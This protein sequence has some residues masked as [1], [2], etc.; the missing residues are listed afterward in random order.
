M[1]DGLR[2]TLASLVQSVRTHGYA[3]AVSAPLLA[4]AGAVGLAVFGVTGS[5]NRA[6]WVLFLSALPALWVGGL[7]LRR[8]QAALRDE[9]VLLAALAASGP[10][11]LPDDAMCTVS[12]R[13]LLESLRLLSRREQ[14][15]RAEAERIGA[16]IE[17]A[18]RL[19][20]D[21][22]ASMGHDLRGPLNSMLGF[23]ELLLLDSDETA[24]RQRPS[25]TT[26]R[27]RTL[28]LLTLLDEMLDWARLSA[29]RMALAARRVSAAALLDQVT[30][31]LSQRLAGRPLR[32]HSELI[33]NPPDVLA[34]SRRIA[35][36][37]VAVLGDAI[38]GGRSNDVWLQLREYSRGGLLFVVNDPQLLIRE[39]DQKR[40]FEAFRPSYAPSGKRIAGLGLGPACAKAVFRAHGGDV[41]F[42]SEMKS[43]T[44]FEMRLPS[45]EAAP[46]PHGTSHV[47]SHVTV[48][49]ASTSG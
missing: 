38:R 31:L 28:D 3:R 33:G 24:E 7:W 15:M 36:A 19:R 29:G 14:S 22:V 25:V 37:V 34:D 6:L 18:Q 35:H 10:L 16:Q 45:L 39:Q 2:S 11:T 30:E 20:V 48:V 17:E 40:F 8:D 12:A 4:H 46:H 43:G 9:R 32:I 27:Q 47:T 1:V 21:F 41:S 5:L 44:V 42:L 49:S 13:R 23:A 26:I